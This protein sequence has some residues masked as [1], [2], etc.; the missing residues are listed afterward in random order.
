MNVL[1]GKLVMVLFFLLSVV[2]FNKAHAQVNQDA[3]LGIWETEEKDGRMEVFKEGTKYKARMLWGKNIVNKD[4]S[5]KK[6]TNNPSVELRDRD[7]VGMTYI[8][9]LKFKKDT[10]DKGQVYNSENGKWYKC[11]V[12]IK[13][14][15]L[16]L[17]GYL[18][19]KMLG[20]TSKW[21][22]IKN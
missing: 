18:G 1:N 11:Y 6:D 16:H 22:R 17:R 9:D 21:N 4:G 5:S 7:I 15:Q 14:D 3:I 12:W 8:K 19:M 13:N 2:S 10:W 20:Q